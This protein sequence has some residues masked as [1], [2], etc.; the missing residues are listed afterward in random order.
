MRCNSPANLFA[1]QPFLACSTSTSLM[2]D[3]VQRIR[4][5]SGIG[6]HQA[7]ARLGFFAS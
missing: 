4:P 1:C 2:P 6:K 7:L 3:R 5:G